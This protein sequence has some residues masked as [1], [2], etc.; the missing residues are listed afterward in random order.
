MDIIQPMIE[1]AFTHA[2]DSRPLVFWKRDY[3]ELPRLRTISDNP[4]GEFYELAPPVSRNAFLG[5]A[6]KLY[7]AAH[8]EHLLIGLG[9]KRGS[10]TRIGRVAHVTGDARTV[11]IPPH[12][13]EELMEHMRSAPNAEVVM[14]H[15]HPTPFIE[16]LFGYS[17]P[18]VASVQDRLLL[19]SYLARPAIAIR[20]LANRGTV[21]CY[22]IKNGLLREF[23]LPEFAPFVGLLL[24]LAEREGSPGP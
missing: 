9:S 11:H 12:L 14:V 13:D 24:N 17:L 8:V 4:Q 23:R 21:R 2:L 16:G 6:K 18:P 19:Y 10:S 22:V 15:N 5:S 7:S 20:S 1:E 3:E